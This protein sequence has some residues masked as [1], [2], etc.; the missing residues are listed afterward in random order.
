M[1]IF[2]ALGFPELIL[3][4][5]MSSKLIQIDEVISSTDR[6]HDSM[7]KELHFS[8]RGYIDKEHA[9]QMSHR[10]DVSLLIQSQWPPY[11]M[12][13]IFINVKEL[14]INEPGEIWQAF[15]KI[16]KMSKPVEFVIVTMNFD[17]KLLI[18]AE[19]VFYRTCKDLLGYR[20]F[21]GQEVPCPE[22]IPA[23]MIESN[24]R[25]C[26]LCEEGWRED[27]QNIF[28]IC[29]G[30]ESMTELRENENENA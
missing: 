15:G 28:S 18:S 17:S 22:A 25:Q 5:L 23:K 20:M 2:I 30:C 21:F 8:N 7:A 6:F 13:F 11:A 29:P 4:W 12:E 9:M 24:W 19:R 26:S 10:F 16:E 14:K 1:E 27:E 3:M